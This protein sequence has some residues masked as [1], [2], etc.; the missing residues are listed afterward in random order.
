VTAIPDFLNWT[1]AFVQSV[2]RL[3]QLK[4][5]R[6]AGNACEHVE[7]PSRELLYLSASLLQHSL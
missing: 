5:E 4:R 3:R 1:I 6:H 2:S 7:L